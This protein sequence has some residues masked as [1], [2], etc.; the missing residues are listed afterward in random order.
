MASFQRMA[1]KGAITNNTT[2]TPTMSLKCSFKECTVVCPANLTVFRES[3][4][5]CGDAVDMGTNQVTLKFLTANF[6]DWIE[7]KV[8]EFSQNGNDVNVELVVVSL[9]ELSPKIINEAQS[10]TGR[11]DGF[12]TPPGV[13]GSIVKEDG[14]ADLRPYID[15]NSNTRNDWTDIFLSYQKLIS[16]YHDQ[17]LMSPLDG[18]VLSLFYCQDVLDNFDF[19]C[20]GPGRN[21]IQLQQQH[22]E[23]FTRTKHRLCGQ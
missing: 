11:F 16:Q 5:D 8:K 13:M 9:A 22:M 3:L 12:I 18:D 6:G 7:T 1:D 23:R 10:K 21:T 17:I 20:Q 14:W 4:D 19:Q 2:E 15:S